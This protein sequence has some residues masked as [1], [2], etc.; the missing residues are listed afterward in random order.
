MVEENQ[1]EVIT[2]FNITKDGLYFVTSKNGVKANL[3]KLEDN[4]QK[5]ITLPQVYGSLSL[6]TRGF[7]YPELW[8][9]ARGWITN[10]KRFEY[11]NG[12]FIDKDINAAR[13]DQQ[14]KDI[15]IEEIEVIAH[16][17]EKIPLSL[18]YNKS[19]NNTIKNRVLMEGYGAFGISMKPSFQLRRLLWVLEGGVYAIAHVRGGG[20]KGDS[21]HKGGQK[22]TKPNT[23]KDFIS[24]AEYLIQKNITTQKQLA[25]WSGSAGGIMIGRAITERPELFAAAI[26]EFGMLNT[27]R[28]ENRATGN[29]IE[30]EYGSIKN[31]EEFK[32]LLEMD[33]YHHI[34]KEKKYP[35]TLLTVGLNDARVPAWFSIKFAARLQ[36][37]NISNT[38]NLLLTN[39][40]TGHGIGDTKMIEFERFA[41]ILSFALWQTG[42]PDYQPE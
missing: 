13:N 33:A 23:W 3:F 10:N 35:S 41:T 12:E 28:S 15:V 11:N 16:D 1:D 25:I 6:N 7:N 32:A 30:K 2:D 27:L 4:S 42:H 39:K 21:W 9:N 38:N 40:N 5:E 22:V 24:C 34:K 37:A 19:I 8:I 14:F 26:V 31:P 20:E 36:A 17:G 29:I 18:F